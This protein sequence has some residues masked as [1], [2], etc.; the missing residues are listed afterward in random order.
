[1][2]MTDDLGGVVRNAGFL[3]WIALVF[4]IPILGRADNSSSGGP[5]N[6]TF[7]EDYDLFYQE[8]F[9][10]LMGRAKHI[11]PQAYQNLTRQW[12]LRYPGLLHPLTVQ[13]KKLSSDTLRHWQAAEVQQEW[14]GSRLRQTLILDIGCYLQN[15]R[16]KIDLILT[17]EMAHVLL[18]DLAADPTAVP[19]PPWFNEGLA[20]SVTDE[21]Q[22]RVRQD[23]IEVD[24]YGVSPVLCDL[25]GPVDEFA[26][27]P[28]NARCYPEYYLAVQRLKQLGG[29]QTLAKVITGLQQGTKMPVLI[30]SITGLTWPSFKKDA[31]RYSRE[32]LDGAK[33]IP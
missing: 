23:L 11:I 32:V 16:E 20:Q 21:G 12:G 22:S 5:L 9:H 8:P 3:L 13:V 17:H 6:V 14:V 28:F 26:H 7:D 24:L 15:P 27:G 18:A 1:M 10:V 25:E 19:I 33:P 2:D 4:L 30:E 31:D 29:P